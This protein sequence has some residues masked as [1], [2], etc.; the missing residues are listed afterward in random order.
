MRLAAPERP[1]GGKDRLAEKGFRLRYSVSWLESSGEGGRGRG[2][3]GFDFSFG[4][5][6]FF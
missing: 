4:C 5:V 6:F 2:I 1:V 3:P